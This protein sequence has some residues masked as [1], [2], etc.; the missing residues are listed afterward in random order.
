MLLLLSM[1]V[2]SC[3]HRNCSGPQVLSSGSWVAP[4]NFRAAGAMTP[5]MRLQLVQMQTPSLLV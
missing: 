5:L 4:C 2:H 3:C 1:L